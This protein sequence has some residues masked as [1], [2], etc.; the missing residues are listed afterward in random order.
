MKSESYKSLDF[1]PFHSLLKRLFYSILSHCSLKHDF[2]MRVSSEST[3]H[4]L[5]QLLAVKNKLANENE[6]NLNFQTTRIVIS[7]SFVKIGFF[8]RKS[9]I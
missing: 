8:N 6:Q 2:L 4:I 5:E 7:T 9:V 1:L 3:L